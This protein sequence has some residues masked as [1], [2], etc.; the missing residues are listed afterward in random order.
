MRRIEELESRSNT[1]TKTGGHTPANDVH[2]LV[3]N[4]ADELASR[5]EIELNV[6]IYGLPEIES[7][8]GNS[9]SEQ[10]EK[11]HVASLFKDGLHSATEEGDIVQAVR[12]GRPREPH[13]KPRPVK[14]FLRDTTTRKIVL[15]KSK[16]LGK[17][18]T[19]HKYKEVFIRPDWTKLQRDQWGVS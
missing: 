6:V 15:D 4:V 16:T 1:W 13:E 14:V 18:P 7:T 11:L 5:K 12:L 17:L 3:S 8:A 10:D 9:A 19:G 2:T